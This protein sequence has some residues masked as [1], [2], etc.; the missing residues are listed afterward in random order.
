MI[1]FL[2]IAILLFAFLVL[3][4]PVLIIEWIIGKFH[5]R[6]RDISSLRI[7]QYAFKLMLWV[8]GVQLTVIGEENVPKDRPVLYI[9][10]HRSYFDI[11]LTYSRCPGLTGFVAKKEMER[12]PLLNIWMKRLYC[13]FLDRK[14]PKEGLKTILT[15]VDYVKKGIS[16]C[17]FPE[18]TRNTGE[19]L[20]MLPFK[21][22]AFKIAERSRCPIVPMSLNNTAE[23]FENHF[24]YVRKTRVVLEYGKPIETE[25]L[26]RQEIRALPEQCHELIQETIRKNERLICE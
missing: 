15:A 3:M 22:G 19:E 16:I 2:I 5:P 7:V 10:N 13:L 1:R 23:M 12:Y 24:P 20:S 9:G 25:G 6:A 4:I 14:N 26:S 11:L 8:S 17:I 18:G 21:D